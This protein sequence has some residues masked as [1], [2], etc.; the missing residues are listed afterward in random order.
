MQNAGHFSE[1]INIQKGVHQGGPNSSLYFLLCAEIVAI[2]LRKNIEG[3]PVNDIKNA[4][5]QYADDMDIYML[6]KESE[7]RK[8]FNELERFRKHVGFLLSYEKTTL[9]RI[10][11]LR[12]S[13]DKMIM[14]DTAQIKWSNDPINV[15]G[16]WIDPDDEV[17]EKLN[18]ENLLH[19]MSSIMKSWEVRKPSLSARVMLVNSLV[20]S[21]LIY[22]MSVLPCPSLRIINK[23]NE[24]V[25][26][27]LWSGAKPKI[28][29]KT[30]QNETNTGGLNLVNLITK[31]KAMKV[32][33][34]Q[35]LQKDTKLANIVYHLISPKLKE[36][37]W[38]CD[39]DST[40]VGEVVNREKFKFWFQVMVAWREYC[41]KAGMHNTSVGSTIIWLNRHVK[42]N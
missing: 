20:Y 23:I 16:I 5:G 18:Y 36:V 14:Q 13:Q 34:S 10:G 19:K 6:F 42:V 35:T 25:E 4:L 21:L 15:L 1:V 32:T 17:V 29:L 33:W 31:D 26:K 38:C 28:S 7:M 24:M 39:I 2:N 30:L 3:I 40:E 12:K 41:K 27:F 37:I 8:V 22:K 11:S 9:Y